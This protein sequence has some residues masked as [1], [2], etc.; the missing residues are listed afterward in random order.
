MKKIMPFLGLF[1]IFKLYSQKSACLENFI[2]ISF[3]PNKGFNFGIDINLTFI[4]IYS[5]P[6]SYEKI[7]AGINT[8]ITFVNFSCYKNFIISGGLTLKS[9]QFHFITGFGQITR[10]SGKNN[11][12]KFVALGP[13]GSIAFQPIYSEFL[14]WIGSFFYVPIIKNEWIES[15]SFVGL[16]TFLPSIPIYF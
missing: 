16:Y 6:N 11:I 4:D 7:R 3:I 10:Y 5:I 9:Q 2:F 8:R 12:N 15:R 14:P 13:I 1:F